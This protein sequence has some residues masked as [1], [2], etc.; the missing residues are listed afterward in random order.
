MLGCRVRDAL[1]ESQGTAEA[2]QQRRQSDSLGDG[3]VLGVETPVTVWCDSTLVCNAVATKSL[4][5]KLAVA[6]WATSEG[7]AGLARGWAAV[8]AQVPKEGKNKNQGQEWRKTAKNI[9][10]EGRIVEQ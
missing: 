3:G 7:T 5:T 2:R 4:A 10:P 9:V 1:K 6:L 8:S